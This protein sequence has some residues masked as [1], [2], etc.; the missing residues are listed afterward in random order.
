MDIYNSIK[1][2]RSVRSYTDKKVDSETLKIILSASTWAPSGKNG[3]PWK[4]YITQDPQLV[5]SISSLSTHKNW[6]KTAP[7][8]IAFFLDKEK[9]YDYIK[10]VLASG[11]AIQNMLLVAHEH[12]IGT[13]W[14]GELLYKSI[15]VKD[16]LHIK[17]DSLE[18]MG[19]LTVGRPLIKTIPPKRKDLSEFMLSKI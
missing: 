10:D 4:V 14:V 1:N 13:C 2:R 5:S 6:M 15:Q 3:Q 19:I 7:C 9:S 11:A 12:G 8:I 16:L 17:N 18:L